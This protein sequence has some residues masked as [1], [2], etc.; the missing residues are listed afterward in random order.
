MSA[1]TE[2]AVEHAVSAVTGSSVPLNALGDGQTSPDIVPVV[3]GS[4]QSR[5]SR[6][7]RS[8]GSVTYR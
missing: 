6:Y 3:Q 1:S 2:I 8:A 4:G 7:L 5:R